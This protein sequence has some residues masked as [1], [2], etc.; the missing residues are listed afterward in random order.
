MISI[1]AELL[2][3][4]NMQ[5]CGFLNIVLLCELAKLLDNN[6]IFTV[7]TVRFDVLLNRIILFLSFVRLLEQPGIHK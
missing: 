5:S 2:C 7:Q 6:W 3:M 1:K 4:Y